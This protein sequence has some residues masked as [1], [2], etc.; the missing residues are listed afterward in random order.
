MNPK[1]IRIIRLVSFMLALIAFG[2]FLAPGFMQ[3]LNLFFAR[4]NGAHFNN[5][6]EPS[7]CP[8]AEK[9]G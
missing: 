1:D 4:E 7:C 3:W 6:N 5:E 8:F 9:S 2:M